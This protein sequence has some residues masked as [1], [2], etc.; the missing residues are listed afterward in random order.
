[1][2]KQIT[3]FATLVLWASTFFAQHPNIAIDANTTADEPSICI[4]P[5]NT[6]RIVAGSNINN[7]YYSNDAGRSWTKKKQNSNFGVYGD[8]VIVCDTAGA[9]YH[10]HLSNPSFGS[11][12]DR[13]VCQKST[14]GGRTW[15]DGSF[16]GLDGAKNQDKH[17]ISIDRKTNTLYCTWTQF[18]KYESTE[19]QDSSHILFS[20][21]T[22]AGK[23]WTAAKRL[24]A[25]GGDCIDDDK[26][27]EGA[28]P[29]VGPNG[30]VYVAWAGPLGL[31]FNRSLDGGATWLPRET[32]IAD[33]GGGWNY[34]IS[35]LF[36]C[37]GLPFT[38]CDTSQSP[39]RGTVYVNWS[40]QRNGE[41]N[42]DVW[43]AKST[44][45]GKNWS[46]P[47]RV[48]DDGSNR[49]QFM[50]SMTLDQSNG[51]LWFLFYDRRTTTGDLT[52][53]YMALSRDGGATFQ[54]FKVSEQPFAPVKSSFFGDYTHISAVNNVVRPIWTAM[55]A[56]GQK[57]IYTALVNIDVLGLDTDGTSRY[58]QEGAILSK[59]IT[60]TSY[61]LKPVDNQLF[62]RFELCKSTKLT[63]RLSDVTGKI[64]STAFEKKAFKKGKH[65]EMI[66]LKNSHLPAD[67]YIYTI[68]NKR[69]KI[70]ARNR[71]V[72]K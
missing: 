2:K 32:K 47:I 38:A 30:E 56:T 42:T 10:F 15:N 51:W 25:Q 23:T 60:K 53:V 18:D 1:M 20:K 7:V 17:W 34:E 62:V 5:K 48:N 3:L 40:D 41:T 65:E 9:F 39:Y 69:G 4:D 14:D 16:M 22:D 63:L 64:V 24:N 72:K 26:T 28:V 50:S 71:F 55:D 31:V 70:L 8:P 27:V 49:Q 19:P 35:G 58:S 57:T 36:R 11:W 33:I 45:G 54:N 61:Y 46:Q 52:D 67:T 21:S 68:E 43:L 29:S 12:I 66:D 37:N 6:K 44:D 59:E 13:I